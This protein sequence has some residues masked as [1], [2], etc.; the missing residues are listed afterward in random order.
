MNFACE[1][2][3]CLRSRRE[4]SKAAYNYLYLS[5]SCTQRSGPTSQITR[6]GMGVGV[7]EGEGE[8]GK[9]MGRG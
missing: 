4:S 6:V 3:T 9:G 8:V 1:T 7:G 2:A 5:S